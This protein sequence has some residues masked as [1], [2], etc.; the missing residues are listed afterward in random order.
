MCIY[1]A[2][3]L[4]LLARVDMKVVR[5]VNRTPL[6]PCQ[7]SAAILWRRPFRESWPLAGPLHRFLCQVSP[8]CMACA[9]GGDPVSRQ[10][11]SEELLRQLLAGTSGD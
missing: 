3:Q 9:L 1:E 8:Q 5:S 10:F 11:R 7:A 6:L 4:E 2:G